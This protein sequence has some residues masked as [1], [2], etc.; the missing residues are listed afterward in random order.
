MTALVGGTAA[1]VWISS[2]CGGYAAPARIFVYFLR[3]SLLIT[4]CW[5]SR[6]PCVCSPASCSACCLRLQRGKSPQ[7]SQV[8]FG[9]FKNRFDQRSQPHESCMVRRLFEIP[10]HRQIRNRCSIARGV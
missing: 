10:G 8:D 9:T 4:A 7:T 5:A 3:A 2:H 6:F 1:S